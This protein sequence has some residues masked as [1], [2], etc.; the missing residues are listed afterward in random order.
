MPS[1]H[2]D[3]VLVREVFANL[4]TNAVKYNTQPEKWVEISYRDPLP[5]AEQR[6][7]VFL[8][9]DNGIGI[10]ER[11]Y[12]AVFKMFRRLHAKEQFS[13]TGAGLAI[14]K[15]IVERHGGSIWVESTYGEGSTFLFTLK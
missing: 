2:C 7:P 15:S 4:I 12:D 9:R 14:V 13:G 11:N 10:R 8:T 1:A 6:G 5:E 3:P